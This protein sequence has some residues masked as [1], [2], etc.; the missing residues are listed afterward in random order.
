MLPELLSRN[1]LLVLSVS[2]NCLFSLLESRSAVEGV[3]WA[4]ATCQGK[5]HVPGEVPGARASVR[6]SVRCQGKC[7][8]PW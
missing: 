5:C 8:V 7:Q 6:E 2:I 3:P 1:K 4:S